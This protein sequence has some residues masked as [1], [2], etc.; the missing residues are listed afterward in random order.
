MEKNCPIC[1]G[2]GCS[3]RTDRA[4]HDELG[5]ICG[6]GEPC[7]CNSVG[8]SLAL[9]SRTQTKFLSKEK[10]SGGIKP[11]PALPA[12]TTFKRL[13]W[14]ARPLRTEWLARPLPFVTPSGGAAL[15]IWKAK[16][17]K[18]HQRT[19]HSPG[20]TNCGSRPESPMAGTRNSIRTGVAE[21]R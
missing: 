13:N 6:A 15:S 5:C 16:N 10:I 20:H 9:M 2:I 21:R 19:N 14:F 1:F 8:G 18:P 3:A 17:G 12:G 11:A 7:R 4:W